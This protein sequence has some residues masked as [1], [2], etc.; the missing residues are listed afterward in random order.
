MTIP[1]MRRVQNAVDKAT[2]TQANLIV[3]FA[4]AIHHRDHNRYPKRLADLTPKVLKTIPQDCFSGGP[5][6]YLPNEN[7]YLLYSV[8]L[9]GKDDNGRD[10]KDD[11][12]GDDLSIRLRIPVMKPAKQ[13]ERK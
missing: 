4:L 2:Q 3:A 1:A 6:V 7:G 9:N 8:G 12:A 10:D 13:E 5:L 11:P